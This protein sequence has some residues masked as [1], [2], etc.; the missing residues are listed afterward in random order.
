MERRSRI[1]IGSR[2]TC[3]LAATLATGAAY[4]EPTR[5]GTSASSGVG[6]AVGSGPA[7]RDASARAGELGDAA[8]ERVMDAADR[9]H[10]LLR[11]GIG[12]AP[13]DLLALEGMTRAEGIA[14]VVAGLATEPS[15]PMP[16]W[17]REPPPHYHARESMSERER[18][19]FARERRREL[20]DLRH[21][22]IE[23]MLAGDS[24]QT[25]RLVLFWHDLFATSFHGTDDASLAMAL[26]NAT[27][28]RLGTGS[29]ATLLG[30]MLRDAALLDYLDANS[31]RAGAPNE[32]LA[33]EFLELF[34]LGEGRYTERDVA[35]AARALT[36]HASSETRTL[37]FRLRTWDQDTDDKTLFG[38]RGAHDADA[39]VRLVLARPAASRHLATRFWQAFVADGTPDVDWLD[40]VSAR[41]RASGHDLATL[42]RDT[43]SSA[44]FWSPAHRGAI[45]RSP[46]DLVVGTARSLGYPVADARAFA[47]SLDALGMAPFAPPDVA[48]WREG[49][50][51][52]AGGA[53]L[54]RR[55]AVER[56]V[57]S[58][59]ALGRVDGA[60]ALDGERDFPDEPLVVRLAAEHFRGPAVWRVS[61]REDGRTTWTDIARVL[62][63]GHDTERRGRLDIGAGLPWRRVPVP[64]PPALLA[65][66]D[67]VAV[68]FLADFAAESGDRNLYVD[69]AIVDGAWL[70]ASD[71]VQ[72][73]A[74]A[75]EDPLAAG[76]LYCR[77]TLVMP[78]GTTTPSEDRASS[79]SP[80]RARAAHVR[81]ANADGEGGRQV[82]DI[83]L[84][85][86]VTPHG[87]FHRVQFRLVAIDGGPVEI[88]IGAF[89]CEPDCVRRWPDC[90][91]R[92]ERFPSARRVAFPMDGRASSA[93][94]PCHVEGVD[95][96][97]RALVA[98]LARS[99][100]P[101]LE[102]LIEQP[103][104]AA[105]ASTLA[106][107]RTRLAET[108]TGSGSG[109]GG[110]ARSDA[111]SAG[112]FLIDDRVRPPPP[113]PAARPV[114][115]APVGTSDE[116][117]VA[118]DAVGLDLVDVMLAG[119]P[120]TVVA[121]LAPR[122]E[123]PAA[124][125]ISRI[126]RHP[127][128]QLR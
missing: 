119:F 5:S 19:R 111:G 8:L 61:L 77:G 55:R 45:V 71:G 63:D 51:F 60:P 20:E 41:F 3:L 34:T 29:W 110:D 52:V 89:D 24:P 90:A 49:D 86:V 16:A 126:A 108:E 12:A 102:R 42:H 97:T 1:G 122:P 75:P 92:D 31:N 112:R 93:R 83:A 2:A 10:L 120:E 81:W 14:H 47:A 82:T 107:I 28:R 23:E 106:A 53:L 43:L 94:E 32:N 64:A 118:L 85:D 88:E 116:L 115:A 123:E 69:G 73:G 109:S 30:A 59:E 6:L 56:I 80:W 74:C 95:G 11:S 104:G 70:D 98:A 66:A 78:R 39:L 57:R 36:G 117:V 13:S 113:I 40:A 38:V 18:Q 25:E 105:H 87:A 114:P 79:D 84:D 17:T 65:R 128:F 4:G 121:P 68:E 72:S 58:P 54:D 50:A 7:A 46:I 101:L 100:A 96:A 26:Q 62:D 99:A 37:A 22:W 103:G 15:R 76:A 91:W 9:R 127:A 27:F 48:G 125:A 35:E 21:W 44:A 124:V 33:R 67:A